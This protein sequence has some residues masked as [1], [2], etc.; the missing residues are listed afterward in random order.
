MRLE[1]KYLV[2]N[3]L[4]PKLR[5]M[6]TPFVEVDK[7]VVDSG[8]RGY[9]VRSVY[10]DTFALDFYYEKMA[11][12][13][14]RKKIRLRG[15]NDYTER[16]IVFLEIK[17]KRGRFVAKNRAPVVYEHIK[18]IF[19]SSD[20]E[21]FISASKGSPN[22]LEDTRRF[23]FYVHGA[24]LR[25]TVLIIYERE[26]YH[27]K[28]NPSLRITFDKNIR[29]SIYPSID[30]LFSEDEILHSIPARFVLEVKFCGGLPLWLKSSIA[31]LGLRQMA[32]SKYVICLDTHNMPQ[33]FSKRSMLAFSH[34][35]QDGSTWTGRVQRAPAQM[36]RFVLP[37]LD[38]SIIPCPDMALDA[39]V[40]E[41]GMV[42]LEPLSLESALPIQD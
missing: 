41:K 3:E 24:S 7:Y 2:P 16:S 11:G 35:F 21:R 6:I 30:A 29:S 31:A 1:Y 39:G 13:K 28:F 22:A 4:L 14:M 25:P 27:S 33:R 36:D 23:L 10:F 37:P 17:R 40:G 9:T 20:V 19:I 38:L 34:N 12:L 26:A 15:Y 42:P 5:A 18:D 8:L 32:L